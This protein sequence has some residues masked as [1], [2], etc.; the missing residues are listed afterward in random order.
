MTRTPSSFGAQLVHHLITGLMLAAAL[1]LGVYVYLKVRKGDFFIDERRQEAVGAQ[2]LL[3]AGQ[4]VRLELAA[5]TYRAMN[6]E[7]PISV[8]ELVVA[9]L[10]DASDLVYPSPRFR[11]TLTTSAEGFEVSV[12]IQDPEQAEAL[13]TE[14]ESSGVGEDAASEE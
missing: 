6:D 5:E 10:L 11:Y 2:K 1:S 7:D 13:E 8:D 3:V 14:Q 12:S 9:G 4:Q